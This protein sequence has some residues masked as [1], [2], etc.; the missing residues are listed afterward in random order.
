MKSTSGQ[1]RVLETLE[2]TFKSWQSRGYNVVPAGVA[3]SG[4][5]DSGVLLWG[6]VQILGRGQVVALWVDHGV[7]PE[8]ERRAEASLVQ[9]NC[10]SL[11]ISLKTFGPPSLDL[12]G[13][14]P[15]DSFRRFRLGALVQGAKDSGLACLLT[16][17]HADD[18]AE[19]LLM[20][21]FQG[22]SWDGLAGIPEIRGPFFRPFLQLSRQE[23][24]QAADEIGLM[25][26]ED[27]SNSGSDYLRNSLRN[28]ILPQIP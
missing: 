23:L 24:R 22:R 11:D 2:K 25:W 7:R 16:A 17:H 28:E 3:Y 13:Q 1:R 20:R 18:Q 12:S 6:A 15:E 10:L 27:T 4:G 5:M 26:H 19:T 14:G 8:A 9:Q 21:L